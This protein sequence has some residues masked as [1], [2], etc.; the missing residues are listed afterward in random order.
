MDNPIWSY[1]FHPPK[2]K[3]ATIDLLKSLPVF[4]KL[5]IRELVQVER[6]LHERKYSPGETV[7][8]EGEPGAGMYIVKK[9]EVTITHK[10]KDNV[11]FQLA[12]IAERSFF[13]ELALLEEMPRSATARAVVESV[14]YGFSKPDLENL[15]ERNHNIGI[16]ILLNL[17]RLLSRRLLKANENLESMQNELISLKIRSD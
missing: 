13:G 5:S 3:K 14:L 12:L 17:S 9:G 11:D 15:L 6:V 2:E 7:F 10:T 4:D 1:F 8:N 16:K